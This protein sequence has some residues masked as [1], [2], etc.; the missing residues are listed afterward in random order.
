V[1][2]VLHAQQLGRLA[3]QQPPRR[4]AGPGGDDLGD[5]VRADLLLD[6]RLARLGGRGRLDHLL[7]QRGISAYISRDAAS[8]SPSR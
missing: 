3:L 5:V 2:L 6:H 1:Q 8:K 4:D 7:L